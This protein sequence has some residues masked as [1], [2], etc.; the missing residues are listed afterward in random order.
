MASTQVFFPM[1][2][3]KFWTALSKEHLWWLPLCLLERKKEES[4]KQRSE[5]KNFWKKEENKNN[6]FNF[7]LHVLALVIPKMQI[8]NNYFFFKF[9]FFWSLRVHFLCFYLVRKTENIPCH[10]YEY[11]H[12]EVIRVNRS[13]KQL[14]SKIVANSLKKLDFSVQFTK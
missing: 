12:K 13:V 14:F 6:S 3:L 11:N 8:F 2:I 9:S 5:E 10:I 4:V 7:Y 1:N